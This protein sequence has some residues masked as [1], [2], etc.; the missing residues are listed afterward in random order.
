METNGAEHRA[1]IIESYVKHWE[2]SS[3]STRRIYWALPK[4]LF[5]FLDRLQGFYRE[6][7]CM[8]DYSAF[9]YFAQMIL[10]KLGSK[11]IRP[12]RQIKNPNSLHMRQ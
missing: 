1:S 8:K 4:C 12:L 2:F 5:N 10:L 11:E 6:E 7:I 3:G 9:K